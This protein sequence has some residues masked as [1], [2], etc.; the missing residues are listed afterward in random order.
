MKNIS[1]LPA[2][3]GQNPQSEYFNDTTAAA[4]VTGIKP[5]TVRSWRTNLGLPYIRINSKICRIKKSDLDRWLSQRRV[6]T[7]KGRAQ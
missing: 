4:Y 3:G 1:T 7:L 2:D 5:R 6:A